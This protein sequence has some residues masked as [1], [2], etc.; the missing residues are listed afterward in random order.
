M[1]AP[2]RLGLIVSLVLSS[3]VRP[4]SMQGQWSA[5]IEV[6]ADR[7]W[8]GSVE[9]AAE[10]RSFHPYRPTAFGAAIQH[11]GG[12]VGL[13]LRVG[14]TEAALALEGADAVVA[15]KG[16]F[17]I[18]SVSPEIR[19]RMLTLGP[20]NELLLQ[21]GPLV[22]VWDIVDQGPRTRAGA[23]VALALVVPL[24]GKINA[25]LSAGIALISS[26]FEEGEL[27]AGYEL[28]TLW[29][30]RLAGGLEYRF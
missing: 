20:G 23:Q 8:G 24:G 5:A 29:R 18:Y 16:V 6:G 15:V 21:A 10:H 28:Q 7:F 2:A 9:T 30:R 13:G 1:M 12:R 26:P 4:S 14:Y 3:W 19:Y 27:I 17:A 11:R 25:A 22:E